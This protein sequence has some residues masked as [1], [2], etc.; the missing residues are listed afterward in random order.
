MLL[1]R[2]AMLPFLLPHFL[3]VLFSLLLLPQRYLR[4]FISINVQAVMVSNAMHWEKILINYGWFLFT[5]VTKCS[6]IL[7]FAFLSVHLHLINK[8]ISIGQAH[9]NS[10]PGW[11][12]TRQR[13]GCRRRRCCRAAHHQSVAAEAEAAA[14]VFAGV[15][16]RGSGCLITN[17]CRG[18][19]W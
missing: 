1:P 4:L 2:L 10:L 18:T 7:H 8:N 11:A 12:A 16:G 13:L 15:S 9:A 5:W 6:P 14:Q 17:M 3:L 19:L